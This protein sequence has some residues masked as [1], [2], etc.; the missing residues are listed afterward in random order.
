[1][2]LPWAAVLPLMLALQVSGCVAPPRQAPTVAPLEPAAVGLVAGPP[3]APIAAQWWAALGDPQLDALM[4]QALAHSPTLEE[5]LA[6]LRLAQ[7]VQAGASSARAPQLSVDA[8]EVRQRLSEHYTIPPPFAGS[9]EWIGEAMANLRWDLD[10]WGRQAAHIRQS[11]SQVEAREFDLAAA[12]LAVAGAVART[13]V[14]LDEAWQ[15]IDLAGRQ[16]AEEEE[17]LRL[18]RQRVAAGLDSQV[19]LKAVEAR[20]PQARIMRLAAE[21][22]RDLAIHR[23]AALVGAGAD[24]YTSIGRPRL[25]EDASLPLPEAL[26][27]D[28]LAHRPDVQAA[29]ARVEAASA[30][31]AAAHAAFYPDVS[32]TAF[33]GMQAIG[34]DEL[35]DRGSRVYG[36]GPALHLPLFDAGRLRAAYRGATAELDAATASYNATVLEAVRETADGIARGASLGR[37]REESRARLAAAARA[38]E[39]ARERHAAGL[40]TRLVVIDAHSQVI[41]A[42]RIVAMAE[43]DRLAARINLLLM[44]GG[45]T[46]AR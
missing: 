3:V 9:T 32:L 43:A 7:S 28:L 15:L 20:I 42:R 30:G 23:L 22:A 6:R 41:D 2:R 4:D 31:R 5:A 18:T 14:E 40:A 36:A 34:L 17:R 10:F 21:N 26:P 11:R 45:G 16:V 27:I 8:R 12:R 13:Y 1:M 44:L 24:R 25:V 19:D 37:Q 33:A 35:V 38:D 39:L 29:R 46:G